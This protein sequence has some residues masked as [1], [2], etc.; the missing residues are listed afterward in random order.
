MSIER[1]AA[2]GPLG[3]P[4]EHAVELRACLDEAERGEF[5]DDATTAAYLRWLET[6]EGPCPWQPE[7]SS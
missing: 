3:P 6:G 2:A 4:A 5:L 7:P 1:N